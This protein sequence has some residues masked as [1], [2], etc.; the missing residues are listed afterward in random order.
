MRDHRDPSSALPVDPERARGDGRTNFTAWSGLEG[1]WPQVHIHAS[2]TVWSGRGASV[3]LR[4]EVETDGAATA[5]EHFLV[6]LDGRNAEEFAAIGVGALHHL[7]QLLKRTHDR[8][9]FLRLQVRPGVV[10]NRL[11]DH[12]L[13]G[14]CRRHP[15]FGFY[16]ERFGILNIFP[17]RG[18]GVARLFEAGL[19]CGQHP[20]QRSPRSYCPFP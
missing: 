17:P 14:L 18:R 10:V 12:P 4:H 13:F 6:T 9:E 20:G 11:V 7:K 3:L 1:A 8:S 16:L 15:L 19:P 5:A 2:A